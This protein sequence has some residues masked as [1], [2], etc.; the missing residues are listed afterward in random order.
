MSGRL[1][2]PERR[3]QLLDVALD[4]FG[5][6][7]YAEAS[8]S[9]IART[10]GI[11]KPVVYQHFVSKRA[12]FLEVLG[13]CGQRLETAIEKATADAEGPRETVENG[14]N[15]FMEFFRENPAMFRTMFSD[16]NRSDPEFAAEVH[17]IEMVVAERIAALI[18]IE[19]MS[20]SDRRLLAHGIVGLAEAACRHWMDNDTGLEAERVAELLASFTWTG[21]RGR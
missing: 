16:A 5:V 6:G 8:M 4:V 7:G 11:T 14:F 13:E 12:L 20:P 9:E 15:A 21:L 18:D 1:P 10:A 17:R 2:G 19:G 3:Q